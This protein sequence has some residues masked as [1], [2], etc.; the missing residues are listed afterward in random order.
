M[1]CHVIGP[2]LERFGD[3]LLQVSCP[4]TR[5]HIL[6]VRTDRGTSGASSWMDSH[7][8]QGGLM[9]LCAYGAHYLR[10]EDDGVGFMPMQLLYS[11][12][13]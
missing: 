12:G 2:Q 5:H 10:R 13:R 11:C 6:V 3:E 9:P 1:A 7:T 8:D 4:S